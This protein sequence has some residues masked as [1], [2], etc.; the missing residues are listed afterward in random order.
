MELD[1][2]NESPKQAANFNRVQIL[3]LKVDITTNVI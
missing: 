2:L 1:Q 3:E